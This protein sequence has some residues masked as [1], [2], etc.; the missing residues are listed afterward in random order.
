MS[1]VLGSFADMTNS[2]PPSTKRG[3]LAT[4]LIFVCMGKMD[5]AFTCMLARSV[6]GTTVS[7]A[8]VSHTDGVKVDLPGCGPEASR[9]I[10]KVSFP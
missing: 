3:E 2:M 7:C 6:R 10:G 9:G 1:P 5:S 4:P 8:P